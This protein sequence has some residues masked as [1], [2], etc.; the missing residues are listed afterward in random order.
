M[1][2]DNRWTR[3]GWRSPVGI[4]TIAAVVGVL[5]AAVGLYVSNR[6]EPS[7]DPYLF[8]YGTT[9]PGHLRYPDIK[10]FVAKAE[11]D[12]VEGEL[13]D[14]GAGYPA[15]KFGAA[16]GTIEGYVLKL[17][18][19]RVDE[20][21]RTMTAMESGLFHPTKVTTAGGVLATAYEWIG[22]TDGLTPLT[23]MWSGPEA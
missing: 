1:A 10:H 19:D 20:A 2:D 23:G 15:A 8:V 12:S 11:R 3:G 18:P 22:T 7:H 17:R 16:T 14:S 9:M 4:S 5:I 13:F 21:L 6:P